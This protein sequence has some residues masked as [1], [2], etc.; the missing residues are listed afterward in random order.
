VPDFLTAPRI[1]PR[2][3][4]DAAHL[5]QR[6]LGPAVER[7]WSVPATG[8]EWDCRT[9]L[10]HMV[11][12]PL[13]HATNLALRS[14]QVQRGVRSGD[15]SAS[16]ADLVR[17]LEHS[18][19]IL[20]QV[21]EAAPP[22]A[23]GAHPAGMSDAQGFVAMSCDE[24]LVHTYDIASALGLAYEPPLELVEPVLRRL[25]PWAPAAAPVWPA[26][27]WATGRGE[28]PG[29]GPGSPDWLAHCAPLAEW[30]GHTILRR[31]RA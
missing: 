16:I 22:E 18:A 15:P 20:A 26:L 31:P 23:R 4:L 7:D 14:T 1:A 24:L 21:A 5:A 12:A 13:F 28:L 11:T 9:T 6:T 30:D 19:A 3:L 29:H 25:F 17:V 10:D 27:L 8:L 2:R